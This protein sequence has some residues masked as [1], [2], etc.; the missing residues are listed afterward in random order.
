[1][2]RHAWPT[3]EAIAA[4]HARIL[5]GDGEAREELAAL[6]LPEL[7]RRIAGYRHGLDPHEVEAAADAAAMVYFRQ[8]VR[9][10]PSRGPMLGWLARI[11]VNVV[12][13]AWLRSRPHSKREVLSGLD[14][15][16]DAAAVL[17]SDPIEEAEAA[18]EH[19]HQWAILLSVARDGA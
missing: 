19:A 6:L 15:P 16:P 3:A 14:L 2:D 10:D 17:P 7:R 1:V 4:L 9:F 8:P 18:A 5:A 12:K 13:K 11:G